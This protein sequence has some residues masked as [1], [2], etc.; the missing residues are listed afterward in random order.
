MIAVFV[1]GPCPAAGQPFR[2]CSH[3]FGQKK[4]PRPQSMDGNGGPDRAR[5]DVVGEKSE[6]A[7]A[8]P[9]RRVRGVPLTRTGTGGQRFFVAG[10][11]GV[12]GVTNVRRAYMP[13]MRSITSSSRS[14]V[15]AIFSAPVTPSLALPP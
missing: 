4:Y 3:P 1:I 10:A 9:A 14:L 7:G 5:R 12:A 2:A 8:T 11:V 15:V 13:V 6:T